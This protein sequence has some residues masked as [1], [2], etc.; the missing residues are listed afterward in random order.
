VKL[1]DASALLHAY[2]PDFREYERSRRWL[3]ET[4]SGPER[5]G[6][7]WVTVLAFLRI[8]TNP[9]AFPRPL[10]I[11][12]ATSV[13]S[14][15]LERPNVSVLEPGARHWEI[16]RDLLSEAQARADLVMDAHIA[17]L[18]LEHGATVCTDDR[19]FARFP[20]LRTLDPL[21]S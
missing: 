13:V 15:W 5:V 18:A 16:L 1:L 14:E 6:L 8:A 20:A 10:S 17:A 21:S 2:D 4:F 19:D 9:R 3:E 12:E 7:A 11:E